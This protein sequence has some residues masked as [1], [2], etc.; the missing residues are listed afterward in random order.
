M[1]IYREPFL[2][3]VIISVTVRY[4]RLVVSGKGLTLLVYYRFLFERFDPDRRL[5]F[6]PSD[7]EGRESNH[8]GYIYIHIYIRL[9]E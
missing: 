2:L 8:D 5:F 9:A 1:L 6:Y 4:P 3:G 7:V